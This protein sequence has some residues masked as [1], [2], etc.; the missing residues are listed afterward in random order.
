MGT[1]LQDLRFGWR[2]LRRN[3]GFTAVAII[4]L[5]LGIGASTA[6]FSLV[7]ATL[8][9]PFMVRNPSRLAGVYTS[10]PNGTGYSST[11]YP[12]YVYY[13]DHNQVFSGLMAYAHISLRWTHGDQTAYLPAAIASS[14]YFTVLGVGPFKG[15]TF[16]PT[17][18]RATGGSAVVV[19]SYQF[20]TRQLASDP[21]TIGKVLT[22]N[23]RPFTVVGVLPKNFAGVDLAWGSVPDI[24]VPMLM[25]AVAMPTNG[26]IDL[27]HSRQARFLLVMGRLKSHVSLEEAKTDMEVAA[28]QLAAAYPATNKGRTAF[29]LTANESRMWPGWRN[30]VVQVLLLL[31]VAVGFVLLIACANVANLL[32]ARGTVRQRET[33]LR[34][35]L[36]GSRGRV[37]RQLLTENI[38]LSM[39]GA[40]AGLLFARLLMQI[41]PS[42]ELTYRMHMNL[43]LRLDHRIFIFALLLS[44]ITAL[45]FGLIPAFKASDINLSH[46]LKEGAHRSLAGA[47]GRRL[48]DAI[49]A[50]EVALAFVSLIGGGLFIRSLLHLESADPGFRP[51]HVLAASIVLLPGQYSPTQGF[52]FYP[53]L[54]DRISNIPGVRSTCLTE[55][56]PLTTVRSVRQITLEGQEKQ[57]L[58]AGITIQMDSVSPGYFRT[59]G[60]PLLRGRDFT[61]QDNAQSPQ[62]AIINKTMAESLWP[63]QDPIGKQFKFQGENVYRQVIGVVA[64]A[65]YHT[66]WESP[67]TYLYLPLAQEY[68]PEVTLFVRTKGNPISYLP[69]VQQAVRAL[70]KTVPVFGAETLE[71][72]VKNSL[73][74]PQLIATL[75]T[76]FG[77]IALVL[78]LVGI[79]GVISYSVA[80][81]TH[82]IGIRMALGAQKRDVLRLVLGQGMML[83]LV[84]VGIGIV[85]ALG[86]TRVMASLLYGVKPNDPLT[87]I[88]VALIL[89][90]VALLG[91]YI[92]A[93]HA[94]KVD[95]MEA[96]RYE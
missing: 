12:D 57:N 27:L 58:E 39:I 62:V 1:L 56:H 74:Q 85:A 96:L 11:S 6:I 75:L 42:F 63:H 65:K 68:A 26:S 9:P 28:R 18:D 10:G 94:T 52:R 46:S 86:L 83:A 89:L 34:L 47:S 33:A 22:L 50:I 41:I 76:I 36:G 67:E 55:F 77:A 84:G 30:S 5:A 95:P 15:R 61:P 14:N 64:D 49:V 25:Q 43:D 35:A 31:G 3:P 16:L 53:Q 78:A 82:E 4:T 92:P 17:E 24:W 54:L 19:V 13:R 69:Q 91:C 2:Q 66:I 7:E 32:L 72:Q 38:L 71:E 45:I 81:R 59:L 79:Y 8:F 20:W 37:I 73:S 70:D 44:L 90:G 87:F 60:V 48:R 40:A 80:G 21:K 88:A 93:R 51:D 23:G 29:V